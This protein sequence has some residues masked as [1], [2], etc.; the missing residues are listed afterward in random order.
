MT[1]FGSLMQVS[2]IRFTSSAKF[3]FWALPVW[4]DL[5][6]CHRFGNLS[7]SWQF[8]TILAIFRPFW[9][10]IFLPK[11]A[12]KFFYKS[13]DVDIFGLE[14]F[15]YLLWRKIWGFF[16]KCWRLFHPNTWSLLALQYSSTGYQGYVSN[17]NLE[18]ID[19]FIK[20][21][22]KFHY[23]M[24][25]IMQTLANRGPNLRFFL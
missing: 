25:H 1:V 8:V 18:S 2:Y 11:I 21:F 13:F 24:I 20:E 10:Q 7:P 23:Q 5:A 14:K 4:P 17:P 19:R 15:V 12:K 22:N 3:N 9:Q 6:I 16:P